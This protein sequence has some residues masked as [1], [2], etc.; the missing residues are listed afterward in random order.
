MNATER[1]LPDFEDSQRLLLA[2]PYRSDVWRLSAEPARQAILKLI[3]LLS[4][5]TSVS[6]VV[7][8]YLCESLPAPLKTVH[9]IA[10]EFDDVWLRDIG[11]L[12]CNDESGLKALSFSFDGWSGIQ[13]VIAA[14]KYFSQNLCN[15]L[16]RPL[17]RS[18]LIAEGGAFTHNG[19]GDWLIGLACLKK[20][21]PDLAENDLKSLLKQLLHGQHLHFFDGALGADETGGHIDNMALFVDNNVLLY[22]STDDQTHPDYKT[23]QALK[24][25]LNQLPEYIKAIPLPLPFPQLAT[26][27]ER[28][29][30]ELTD[31]SLQRTVELPLLCSYVNV[32]QTN[33]LVVVPQFGL[34]T[35]AEAVKIIQ[36]ALPERRVVAFDAREFILGGGGLHCIS[37]NLP[38]STSSIADR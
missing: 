38:M 9:H 6:L 17:E 7:P 34:P 1:W 3:T 16:G 2:W 31:L 24:A 12:W 33:E 4:G 5:S 10:L 28:E 29:G 23:C 8:A 15:K 37:H 36:E 26:G 18:K 13:Q 27:P 20:R 22:A 11:P 25:E 14:D 30:I 21:N 19:K 35:D 32:L